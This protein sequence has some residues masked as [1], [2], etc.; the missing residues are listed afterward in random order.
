MQPRR[1]PPRQTGVSLVEL[2]I[3]MAIGVF[4]IAGVITVFGKT[5]DLYR[6]NETAARMQETARYAVSTLEADLRMAN[7]WGLHSSAD[8]I[9][10]AP[11]IDPASRPDP[12]PTYSL[13]ADLAAAAI[14]G[15]INECGDL[16]AI[17]LAAY[18]EGSDG[19]YDLD[20]DPDVGT[21]VA[22]ADQLSVRRASTVSLDAAELAASD[23]EIKLATSRSQGTLFSGTALPAGY[24]AARSE[25]RAVRVHGYYVSDA[26]DE[27][28]NRPSLR[29]KSLEYVGGVPVIQDTQVVP[30]VEDLQVELGMDNDG[31]LDADYFVPLNDAVTTADTAV[32]ARIWL[33]V[34][35]ERPEIGFTDDRTYEYASRQGAAAYAPGDGFRRLLV[36]KTIAL[37]N[38][39]R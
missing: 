39:R 3:A 6:T 27:G 17:K 1:N 11:G 26:S 21:A 9:Q 24:V 23:R 35:S 15:P 30:D 19:S 13:P 32:A 2:M 8:L 38:T 25:A 29:R 18:I 7:Y 36:S 5:R 31:D 33:M 34:R 37:R 28:A 14:A 10:N 16:W 12:D 22:G 20:C 4:L